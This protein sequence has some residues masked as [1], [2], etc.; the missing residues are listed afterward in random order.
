MTKKYDIFISHSKEDNKLAVALCHF[1][2]Q[3]RFRCWIAP[4][5]VQAGKDYASCIIDAIQS[6][7]IMIVILSEHSNKSHHV[8]NEVERAFNHQ[9]A[10]LPFRIRDVIPEQSL[11]YFLSSYHWLDAIDGQAENY[12][13]TLYRHCAALLNSDESFEQ[14]KP[15]VDDKIP[16][17][18]KQQDDYY[19]PKPKPFPKPQINN[20]LIY[21]GGG[22]ILALLLFFFFIK[23]FFN[24]NSIEFKNNSASPIYIKLDGKIDTISALSSYIY[25]ARAKSRVTVKPYT[26]WT[27]TK[28]TILGRRIEWTVDTVIHS[29]GNFIYPL[30]VNTNYFF[31]KVINTSNA[32]INYITVNG[33]NP[34]QK[35]VVNIKIP[36]DGVTY[37]IGYFPVFYNTRIEIWNTTNYYLQWNN[38]NNVTFNNVYNQTLTL[39]YK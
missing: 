8:R 26:Y 20:K 25:T 36:N 5:D 4:R 19:T 11:E 2:E 9:V 3:N 28:G 21:I 35:D 22:L 16:P 17:Y 15:P 24:K 12:F 32:N 34:D 33:A 10:I 7:R 23:P 38:G 27:N 39:Q 31:L 14:S 1:L 6:S 18:K 30:N 13:D 29:D 37:Y